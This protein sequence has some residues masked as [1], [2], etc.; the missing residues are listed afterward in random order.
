MKSCV[1]MQNKEDI[2]GK[3]QQAVKVFRF[4]P[5]WVLSYFIYRVYSFTHKSF[6]FPFTQ[7]IKFSVVVDTQDSFFTWQTIYLFISL[8]HFYNVFFLH[9]FI[10]LHTIFISHFFLYDS[11]FT[12]DFPQ[13]I[14]SPLAHL[15]LNYYYYFFHIFYWIQFDF[16]VTSVR[17]K[18]TE[19]KVNLTL[20]LRCFTTC[21]TTSNL[22]YR[23]TRH[24][25]TVN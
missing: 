9:F 7:M 1:Y 8:L 22:F 13:F 19:A 25:N 16:L 17:V 11:F 21:F 3:K 12:C 24:F 5:Y 23:K 4:S 15:F 2:L 20:P 18:L 14:Y 6:M 10:I